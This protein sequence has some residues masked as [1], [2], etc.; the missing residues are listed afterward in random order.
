MFAYTRLVEGLLVAH[1]LLVI[2]YLVGS[3]ATAWERREPASPGDAMVRLVCTCA[4]GFAFLGFGAFLIA[5]V[6]LFQPVMAAAAVVAVFSSG[7]LIARRSPF[8]R[9]YWAERWG[10]VFA[11]LD[12]PHI[13]VYFAMLIVAFPAVNLSNAG[14]DPLAF[15]WAYAIDF[16]RAGGLVVDPFLREPFYAQ[17][18]LMLVALVM[19]FGGGVFLQF[20]MWMLGLL[21][22]FGVCAGVRDSLGRGPWPATIGVLLA[23]AVTYAPFYLR[24][25][26]SGFLDVALGF[27]ALSAILAIRRALREE[28][29]DWRWLTIAA[30]L[31]AFLIGSKTSL[32]PFVFVF[33]FACVA[34]ARRLRCTRTQIAVVVGTLVV[35]AAPWYARNLALAGDPIAPWIN[36]K[37]HGADGLVTESEWKFIADDLNTD[38][39]PVSLLTVPLR[40]FLTPDTAPFREFSTNALILLLYVPS[41]TLFIL[42]VVLIRKVSPTVSYPILLLTVLIAYWLFSSTFA[43]YAL[44]FYPTLALCCGLAISSLRVSLARAGPIF[45]VVCALALVIS[46]TAEA[47]N[48]YATFFINGVR[49]APRYY[50]ADDPFLRRFV[51]G[52]VEEK[53][54]TRAMHRLGIRGNLYLLGTPINYYYSMDGVRSIGDWI[55]PAGYLRFYRSVSTGQAAAFLDEL[56]VNAVVVDP[57]FAQGGLDIPIGERLVAAGY[58][59]IPIPESRMSFYVRT[60]RVCADARRIAAR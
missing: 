24:W 50:T 10:V 56:D 14:S 34:A 42:S 12:A 11:A 13:I 57:K 53:F 20:V 6:G 26:D 4:L 54:V 52:Y 27:F 59:A 18:D 16:V 46:P 43:R 44:L 7:C 21:T 2:A 1:L 3:N 29:P 17:N 35:L 55:G 39:R 30:V 19:L 40:L 45:A 25:M 36:L 23:L 9:S 37:L 60:A 49:N 33:G 15:H 48:F 22:A 41:L 8:E 5:L 31:A 28:S 47:A 58:C 51:D 32:L 38:K